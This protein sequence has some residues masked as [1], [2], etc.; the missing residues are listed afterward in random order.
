[1]HPSA[2]VVSIHDISIHKS[3]PTSVTQAR[4]WYSQH[5]LCEFTKESSRLRLCTEGAG[6][7]IFNWA[8]SA[9]YCTFQLW[10][11]RGHI[12]PA[13]PQPNDLCV[14]SF[15]IRRLRTKPFKML[16]LPRQSG[17][18]LTRNQKSPMETG[19][20][21]SWVSSLFTPKSFHFAYVFKFT[22]F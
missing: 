14:M 12:I 5:F 2:D 20:L 6:Q 19:G 15:G 10:L 11:G 22:E 3:T 16:W 18:H 9:Y 1:V 13:G 4:S 17:L 7:C 21:C 8:G